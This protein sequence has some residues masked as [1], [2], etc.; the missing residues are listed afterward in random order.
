M[1]FETTELL[2][3]GFRHH[4]EPIIVLARG[5]PSPSTPLRDSQCSPMHSAIATA[6]ETPLAENSRF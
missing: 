6:F 2:S 3:F 4:P 1:L 5:Y